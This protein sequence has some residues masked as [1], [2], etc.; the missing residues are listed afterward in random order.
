MNNKVTELLGV[1]YPIIQGGL[2]QLGKSSLV[3]AVA[4][5]GGFGLITA[6]SYKNKQQMLDDID[7]VKQKTDQPF[8]VNIAIGIRQ[9]MDEY[10]E[11]V[12]EAEI[13]VVFTSG[14]SP[15]KYMRQFMDNNIKVFH[16]VPN[17][18]FAKKAEELGCSG[19][20]AVG[21]DCGGHPGK[22]AKSIQH[23]IPEIVSSVNI[24]VI[25]AGGFYNGKGLAMAQILGAEAV[26]YGTRF[27][28]TAE[29]PLHENIKQLFLT[30][31]D[32]DTTIIKKSIG[33]P[34]RVYKSL[35]SDKVLELEAQKVSIEELLPYI[36]G[37]AYKRML[38]TGDI[39]NGVISLGNCIGFIEDI[40]TVGKLMQNL[41]KE[42]E[43][44]IHRLK[45]PRNGSAINN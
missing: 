39:N 27:V 2:F 45:S 31:T 10:V 6:G 38:Q 23:L 17:V 40:P 15:K 26:Q 4:E 9:D 24:P 42:Y 5:A 44:A 11:G 12:I 37:K 25:A 34:N 35:V 20:V 19:V 3:S 18:K 30:A 32:E 21:R 28:M 16:V 33:K 7:R 36:G 8:G 41:V 43:K 22:N 14:Y 13:P 1:K 29:C